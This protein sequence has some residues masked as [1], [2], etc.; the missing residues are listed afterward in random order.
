MVGESL[1]IPAPYNEYTDVFSP[2]KATELPSH[3]E[4]DHAI[5]L[6]KGTEPPFSPIYNLS[7]MEL[8]VLREYLAMN[9]E[10]GFIHPSTSPAGAPILFIKKKDGDLRLCVDYRGLNKI[11]VKNR[12]PIPLISESLD[13]LSRAK[14]YT[15][16]DIRSAYNLIHIKAGDEWK[17]AFRTRYGHFEYQVLPFGLSNAPA[18]FQSY[19]N[20]A[21]AELLDR[22][23]IVYLDDILIFSENEKDHEAHVYEILSHLRQYELYVKLEKC[24][25][26]VDTV[27]F[28]GYVI[29]R[30]GITME[31]SRVSTIIQ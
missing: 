2:E 16:L 14:I 8:A 28:L 17:T 19:I 29:S 6:Y 4:R 5:A 12:Y 27:E 11:T 24:Q 7:E 1:D 9:L 22:T 13:K 26:S 15:K 21:L 10:N 25:F 3:G 31:P 20:K 30:H 18:T 23:C